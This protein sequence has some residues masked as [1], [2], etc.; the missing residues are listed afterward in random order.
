MSQR[1]AQSRKVTPKAAANAAR[2]AALENAASATA[3][4][5]DPPAEE[6]TEQ[7]AKT[8]QHTEPPMPIELLD[9]SLVNFDMVNDHESRLKLILA[10]DKKAR[11]HKRNR[12]KVGGIEKWPPLSDEEK[13]LRHKLDELQ[14][15]HEGRLELHHLS[16]TYWWVEFAG[17]PVKHYPVNVVL[18]VQGQ[19]LRFARKVP[20]IVPGPYLANADE[21]IEKQFKQ[22]IDHPNP[23]DEP[24]LAKCQY[25]ILTSKG[26]NGRATEAEYLAQKNRGTENRHKE[27][28]RRVS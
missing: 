9:T 4:V 27:L 24:P 19:G 25:S 22:T 15:L 13:Y 28:L 6:E 16:D 3:A 2:K 14:A 18:W 10:L 26:I 23:I 11:E 1:N 7:T 12:T 17:R 5:L 20:T 21:Q 8:P